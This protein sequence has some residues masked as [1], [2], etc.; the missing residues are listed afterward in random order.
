MATDRL[1]D[2]IRRFEADAR[3]LEALVAGMLGRSRA[4]A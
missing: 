4:A 2:G 1:A 3:K